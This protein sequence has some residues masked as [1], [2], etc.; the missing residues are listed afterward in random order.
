MSD[1][2]RFRIELTG[3]EISQLA[4]S[5]EFHYQR[6]PGYPAAPREEQEMLWHLRQILRCVLMEVSFHRDDDQSL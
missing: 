5:V 6:W 1:N 3:D 2:V 4:K